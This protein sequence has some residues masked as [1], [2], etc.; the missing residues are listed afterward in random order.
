M[1]QRGDRGRADC[2]AEEKFCM[3][4]KAE[5]PIRFPTNNECTVG[6]QVGVFDFL[7][8]FFILQFFELKTSTHQQYRFLIEP[9]IFYRI[10]TDYVLACRCDISWKTRIRCSGHDLLGQRFFSCKQILVEFE[11]PSHSFFCSFF[12]CQRFLSLICQTR[13]VVMCS[14]IETTISLIC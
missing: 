7:L 6:A 4:Y 5:I 1:R 10:V 8:V 12:H 13:P 2:V 9:Y 14:R 3:V 11:K